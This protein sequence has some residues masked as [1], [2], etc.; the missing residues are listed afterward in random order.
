VLVLE[1][2]NLLPLSFA[3]IYRG[4]LLL[5]RSRRGVK[6]LATSGKTKEKR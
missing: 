5:R 6:T 3:A 4:F 1:C 2:G